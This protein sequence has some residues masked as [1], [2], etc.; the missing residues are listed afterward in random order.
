MPPAIWRP[1]L[2][3]KPFALHHCRADINFGSRDCLTIHLLAGRARALFKLPWQH[4]KNADCSACF[5]LSSCAV[6][7]SNNET[8]VP[9][10]YE[11][12]KATSNAH[13][14]SSRVPEAS[15]GTTRN[16]KSKLARRAI[17]PPGNSQIPP[18]SWSQSIKIGQ[19]SC[20]SYHG[21]RL[22][23]IRFASASNKS[24]WLE[25]SFIVL[26][27]CGLR[28]NANAKRFQHKMQAAARAPLEPRLKS[29]SHS[30]RGSC[31]E[32]KNAWL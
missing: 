13:A 18:S 23:K 7:A 30:C 31:R 9:Y 32:D 5:D 25:A 19:T 10:V 15:A 3:Q 11:N 27:T 2:S 14:A 29:A 16:S 1:L 22:M 24:V 28:V 4:V 8:I 20:R 17:P 26:S 21:N 6:I 12:H